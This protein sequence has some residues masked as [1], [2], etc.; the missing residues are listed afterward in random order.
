MH[1]SFLLKI[2]LDD[3]TTSRILKHHSQQSQAGEETSLEML[4]EYNPKIMP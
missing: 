1:I 4:P 3:Q 2:S